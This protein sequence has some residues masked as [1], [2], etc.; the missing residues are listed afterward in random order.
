MMWRRGGRTVLI[1]SEHDAEPALNSAFL[2][3]PEIRLL[4]SHP[5]EEGLEMARRERPTLIIED[6][7]SDDHGSLAF[8]RR[9]RSDPA[10]RSIPLILVISP[11]LRKEARAA[12]ADA[13]LD[14]PLV[15][16]EFYKAVRRFVP[17]PKRRNQRAG[18]NL[19]FTY[20]A[21]DKVGQAF[22]RDVSRNGAFL[23]TDRIPPLGTRLDLRFTLPGAW[24]EISC[25]ALVRIT[26]RCESQPS[27]LSGFGIEFDELRAE[28]AELLEQFIARHLRRRPRSR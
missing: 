27:Q 19:R 25:R 23:K 4:N 20:R 7:A 5:N 9:L 3:Q 15:N 8:C 12:K 16:R 14:K 1:V 13:L 10:T 6:L 11:E 2:R 21:G 18:V 26:A 24:E 17:L 28:D 22:S